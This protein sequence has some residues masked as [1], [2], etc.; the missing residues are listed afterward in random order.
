MCSA[1][2]FY[3]RPHCISLVLLREWQGAVFFPV[4]CLEVFRIKSKNRCVCVRVCVHAHMRVLC[5]NINTCSHQCDK[6]LEG[7]KAR[8]RSLSHFRRWGPSCQGRHEALRVAG[9][10][11]QILADGEAEG[12]SCYQTWLDFR[13]CPQQAPLLPRTHLPKA[14]KSPAVVPLLGPSVQ[15]GE[16]V[17]SI[18]SSTAGFQ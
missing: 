8:R 2:S 7:S 10:S 14:L 9:V 17:E 3:L 4:S 1:A 12:L 18:S 11:G 15:T 6:I 16:S 13:V 5:D